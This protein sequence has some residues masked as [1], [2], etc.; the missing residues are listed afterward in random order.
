MTGSLVKGCESGCS[1]IRV[2]KFGIFL[3]GLRK[4]WQTLRQNSWC[5]S[6]DWHWNLQNMKHTC[7][8]TQLQH[9]FPVC[10]NWHLFLIFILQRPSECVIQCTLHAE[11]I[12]YKLRKIEYL[13]E[14]CRWGDMYI[15]YKH[16]ND[17]VDSNTSEVLHTL[18]RSEWAV[19]LSALAPWLK[20]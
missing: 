1:I 9:Q 2:T 7:W 19:A 15:L 4:T 18:W 10:G 16:M 20:S 14:N 17:I 13:N 12:H 8:H 6:W 5:T 11:F 3:E